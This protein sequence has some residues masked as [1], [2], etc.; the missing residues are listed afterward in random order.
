M[1]NSTARTA[2]QQTQA[3]WQ[4]SDIRTEVAG[5]RIRGVK[6]EDLG[7]RANDRS[8]G[9]RAELDSQS[10]SRDARHRP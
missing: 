9:G 8:P 5:L 7:T 4:V 6:V 1:T 10:C 2:G 3:A